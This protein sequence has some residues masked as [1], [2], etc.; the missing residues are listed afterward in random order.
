[1]KTIKLTIQHGLHTAICRKRFDEEA[2]QQSLQ[3]APWD[4]AFVFDDIDDIVHSWEDIFNRILDSH[5]PW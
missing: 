3:E 1:M 4:T 2:F 5:C